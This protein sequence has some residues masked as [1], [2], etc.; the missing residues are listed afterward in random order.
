MS[1]RELHHTGSDKH[2]VRRDSNGRFSGSTDVGEFSAADQRRPSKM[3][4]R[5]GECHKGNGSKMR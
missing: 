2:Y 1:K 5:R 3:Q 4:V